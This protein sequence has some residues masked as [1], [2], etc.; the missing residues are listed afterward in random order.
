ME[1]ERELP[2][3][4]FRTYINWNTENFRTDVFPVAPVTTY[5]PP[6]EWNL[7]STEFNRMIRLAGIYFY[8]TEREERLLSYVAVPAEM[9]EGERRK[10]GLGM[11]MFVHDPS[12]LCYPAKSTIATQI[13]VWASDDTRCLV[14]MPIPNCNPLVPLTTLFHQADLVLRDVIKTL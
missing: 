1:M 5:T 11:F 8:D 14:Y 13:R 7:D 9:E 6:E 3:T 4:L 10:S 2:N 12:Y